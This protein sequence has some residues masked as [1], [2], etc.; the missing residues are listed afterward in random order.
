MED[1]QPIADDEGSVS[2][3]LGSASSTRSQKSFVGLGDEEYEVL[4]TIEITVSAEEERLLDL[5]LPVL[6]G[7]ARATR[8]PTALTEACRSSAWPEVLRRLS[9][10]P[11][12][13]GIAAPGGDHGLPLHEALDRGAPLSVAE[14]LLDAFPLAAHRKDA[15]GKLPLFSALGN[16]GAADLSGTVELLLDRFPEAALS[17]LDGQDNTAL[18]AA[19]AAGAPEAVLLSLLSKAPEAAKRQNRYGKLP[20]HCYLAASGSSSS[21]N[22]SSL[23]VVKRLLSE[24]PGSPKVQD[25]H[26]KLPLHAAA[27]QRATSEAALL[28]LDRYPEA[29]RHPNHEGSLP[30]HFAASWGASDG[31]TALMDALLRSYPEGARHEDQQGRLPL[32]M[33]ASRAA[34]DPAVVVALL[35]RK[36]PGGAWHKTRKGMLPLNCALEAG[37]GCASLEVVRALL[38]VH[39]DGALHPA[40]HR[41]TGAAEL[42][43]FVAI[44]KRLSA[45]VVRALLHFHRQAALVDNELTELPLHAALMGGAGTEV[46]QELIAA[47]PGSAR[48]SYVAPE[49][50]YM[51]PEDREAL[52]VFNLDGG[53]LAAVKPGYEYTAL[54][55][56][57]S[58][59]AEQGVVEALLSNFPEAAEELDDDDRTPL[60]LAA[61]HAAPHGVVCV[62]CEACPEAAQ[63]SD[64]RGMTPLHHAAGNHRD[65][66]VVEMLLEEHPAAAAKRCRN[67]MVPLD[68][69]LDSAFPGCADESVAALLVAYLAFT[70]DGAETASY[71]AELVALACLNGCTTPRRMKLLLG[72]F[73]GAAQAVSKRGRRN[74]GSSSSG[75]VKKVKSDPSGSVDGC[76]EVNGSSRVSSSSREDYSDPPLHNAVRNCPGAAEVLLAAHPAAAEARDMDGRLPLHV[77]ARLWDGGMV[78][79]LLEAFPG[80]AS[81]QTDGNKL[82]PIHEALQSAPYHDVSD[83]RTAKLLLDA[84][85][86][87]AK[88]PHPRTG[89][90][91]LFEALATKTSRSLRAAILDTWPEAASTRDS[92]SLKTPLHLAAAEGDTETANALLKA[93]PEASRMPDSDGQLPI[94]VAATSAAAGLLLAEF[95]GGA[96]HADAEGKLPLHEAVRR[97]DDLELMRLLLGAFP[98]GASHAADG[99]LPLHC[100]AEL[101]SNASAEIVR[102]LLERHP[103]AA[104]QPDRCGRLPLHLSLSESAPIGTFEALLAAFPAAASTQEG[105]SGNLPLH[106]EA[107]TNAWPSALEALLRVHPDGAACG[108][109]KGRLPLHCLLEAN[110]S[111][112][113]RHAEALSAL[114]A[115]FPGAADV[116]HPDGTAPLLQLLNK[117][118][119]EETVADTLGLVSPEAARRPDAD[120]KL[121]LHHAAAKDDGPVRC[122]LAAFPEAAAHADS[123]GRLPLHYAA[124][125]WY[126]S[127]GPVSALLSEFPEGAKHADA[128]GKLPLHHCQV[129]DDATGHRDL[130]WMSS[131]PPSEFGDY[132]ERGGAPR[133]DHWLTLAALLEA[134]PSAGAYVP[135]SRR[136]W[137]PLHRA[138]ELNAGPEAVRRILAAFPEAVKQ[139]DSNGNLPLHL[140]A[141]HG[142]LRALATL[143]LLLCEFPGAAKMINRRGSLPLHKAAG[144]RDRDVGVLNALVA[145]H[146]GG[147][148][149]HDEDEDLPLDL[150]LGKGHFDDGKSRR[151]GCVAAVLP[152]ASKDVSSKEM[153]SLAFLPECAPLVGRLVSEW[154]PLAQLRNEQGRTAIDAAAPEVRDV[155]RRAL[156][157][158][159]RY[160]P[161]KGELPHRSSTCVVMFGTDTAVADA[162]TGQVDEVAVKLMRDANHLLRELEVRTHHELGGDHVVGVLRVHVSRELK[163][164]GLAERLDA[165]LGPK[166]TEW[167]ETMDCSALMRTA[168]TAED[169]VPSDDPINSG[170]SYCC[171][172]V[173]ERAGC[174]LKAAIDNEDFAGRRWPVVR[175]IATDLAEALSHLHGAGVV[176]GDLK[177]RNVVRFPDR[178]RLIDLDSA[179][180]IGAPF[181]P[182]APST[183]Y[184]PPEMARPLLLLHGDDEN[185]EERLQELT[186]TV[187]HDLWCFGVVLFNLATGNTLWH[188]DT[189][190]RAKLHDLEQVASWGRD[191]CAFHLNEAKLEDGSPARDLLS[192]LLEADPAARAEHFEG[193]G[194]ESV[195]RHCFFEQTARPASFIEEQLTPGERTRRRV[196]VAQNLVR[197]PEGGFLITRERALDLPINLRMADDERLKE[198]REQVQK[199]YR[200][201]S[202]ARKTLIDKIAGLEGRLKEPPWQPDMDAV[203]RPQHEEMLKKSQLEL[204][205]LGSDDACNTLWYLSHMTHILYHVRNFTSHFN[206]LEGS[207][208]E[209]P[210]NRRH[211]RFVLDTLTR[212]FRSLL[213]LSE[214]YPTLAGWRPGSPGFS[215]TDRQEQL[216]GWARRSAALWSEQC[217]DD[218]RFPIPD[219]PLLRASGVSGP[220]LWA[221]AAA[222]MD[223]LPLGSAASGSD[224]SS[225]DWLEELSRQLQERAEAGQSRTFTDA[226]WAAVLAAELLECTR[227]Q[228]PAWT[229][230]CCSLR[231]AELKA[232]LAGFFSSKSPV[233]GLMGPCSVASGIIIEAGHIARQLADGILPL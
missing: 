149:Q 132:M 40:R 206:P 204:S 166:G 36:Y 187:A 221:L 215:L 64:K 224:S 79:A 116:A 163:A 122:V 96:K 100:A 127:S 195:L 37:A 210:L 27:A 131:P 16:G 168:S 21:N 92:S 24:H 191:V 23:E 15:D 146:P 114:L 45:G 108:S 130:S 201:V 38:D 226:G 28:L 173:M 179:C 161:Q 65:P 49:D 89:R 119:E 185:G 35:L 167:E 102:L 7:G 155:I 217:R 162:P 47:Y 66:R 67:G 2:E 4:G 62:L 136:Q 77:A 160:L 126:G 91:P 151:L 41:F 222:Q 183:G 147:I 57:V 118:T 125:R 19:A 88:E 58:H 220:E 138:A 208:L 216:R 219:E 50:C 32:H 231:Q 148:R 69:A 72:A 5:G 90:I 39:P 197:S 63:R 193:G 211:A 107:A 113:Q 11:L 82:L 54:H 74:R 9:E 154:P 85:P 104:E 51:A 200:K 184:C 140:A 75:T 156:C 198:Y 33:A 177:P 112:G 14:A 207:S 223:L 145:A 233:G 181:G 143:N 192:K 98:D 73:P 93:F 78:G 188:T 230:V 101:R 158:L 134:N 80:G 53:G 71:G 164:T 129:L 59:G 157:Y 142:G 229:A 55:L 182:K 180:A 190:D 205:K 3:G 42:P 70:S 115:A 124:A 43:L 214:E 46:V 95:P 172:I 121:L 169:G 29:A 84:F 17:A 135:A 171:C 6:P 76:S 61:R 87:A 25:A 203:R 176:H 218:E 228:V 178:W 212:F 150:A 165:L 52:E 186:G 60:H 128:D 152:A 232:R 144:S 213:H 13:A 34:Q 196:V 31:A 174:N 10:R 109:K 111:L 103:E 139:R 48:R 110:E 30:L 12:D 225:H 133:A 26:G 227:G 120:G 20:I 105:A 159:G 22:D 199:I 44:R 153:H 8:E 56:A 117:A 170:S 94:H 202:T 81:Q 175:S 123:S 1:E 83:A 68:Y 141:A 86:G 99:D 194:M 189:G 18:H 137:Q 97:G 106:I 209:M